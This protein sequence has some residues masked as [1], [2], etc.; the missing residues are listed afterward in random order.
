MGGPYGGY[1][2]PADTCDECGL[3]HYNAYMQ[4]IKQL[5]GLE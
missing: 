5:A 3:S 1:H 2:D 4:L